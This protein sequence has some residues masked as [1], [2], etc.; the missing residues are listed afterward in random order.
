[1]DDLVTTVP[2]CAI[3]VFATSTKKSYATHLCSYVQFC[4]LLYCVSFCP[5]APPV[6]QFNFDC[7]TSAS[8]RY[9]FW[10]NFQHVFFVS[11]GYNYWLGVLIRQIQVTPQKVTHRFTVGS[12]IFGTFMIT[13]S[14]PSI[15]DHL[16]GR[17]LM[18]NP[19]TLGW[20][21]PTQGWQ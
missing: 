11:R 21:W 2:Y 19:I 8:P 20:L 18:G 3:Q 9:V 4:Q 15:W 13:H 1:M 6:P 16:G 7:L 14:I 10:H 5:R 17:G 12:R